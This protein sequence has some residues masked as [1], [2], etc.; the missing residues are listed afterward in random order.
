MRSVVVT[1]A[2][3]AFLPCVS[4]YGADGRVDRRARPLVEATR[5]EKSAWVCGPRGC[6]TR[7]FRCPDRHSC[8]PIYGAYGPFGGVNYWSA[9]STFP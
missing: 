1:L 4:A 8:S 3:A 6:R 5:V 2:L 7:V 9:F